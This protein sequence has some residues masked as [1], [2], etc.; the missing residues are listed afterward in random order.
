MAAAARLWRDTVAFEVCQ[1]H[2]WLMERLR[3]VQ[4]DGG[5]GLV[6]R[7]PVIT[8]YETGRTVNTLKVK[9]PI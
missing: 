2:R 5:E 6:I 3:D 9:K 8:R 7:N 4:S 1:S